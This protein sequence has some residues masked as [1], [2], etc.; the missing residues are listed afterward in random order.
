MPQ[1]GFT[2]LAAT[3]LV[4]ALAGC[5]RPP[6]EQGGN[7]GVDV[8]GLKDRTKAMGQLHNIGVAYAAAIAS[9]RPPRNLNEL[10]EW[11]EGNQSVF[12]AARDRQPFEVVWNV[13]P[14]KLTTPTTETLLAW[15]N[16]ADEKGGRTVLMADCSTVKHLSRD[17]FDKAPRAKGK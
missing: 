9:G 14:G 4:L 8:A 2:R 16:T 13:D 12:N 6:A 15:E 1:R 11:T 3:V 7:A 10:K 5:S 17:E